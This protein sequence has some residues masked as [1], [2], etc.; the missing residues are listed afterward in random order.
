MQSRIRTALDET[1]RTHFIASPDLAGILSGRSIPTRSVVRQILERTPRIDA[2]DRVL[3]V[4][5]G[6]GYLPAVVSRL[7]REVVVVEREPSILRIARKNLER[8]GIANVVLVEGEGRAGSPGHG[9]FDLI[10]CLPLLVEIDDLLEQLAEGGS[11]LTLVGHD[12]PLMKLTRYRRAGDLMAREDLGTV[13]LARE[14]GDILIDL[15]YV[16]PELLAEARVEA[17]GRGEPV[18]SVIRRSL[19]V[20]EEAFFRALARQHN[21][22]FARADELLPALDPEIFRRFSRTFLDNHRLIPVA[23]QGGRLLL[24]TDDPD[25]D[26]VDLARMDP[27]VRLD[28]RLVTPTDFRRLWSTIDLS[29][30]GSE[31]LRWADEGSEAPELRDLLETGHEEVTQY[32]VSVYENILLDAVSARASDIHLERYD[33]RIRI[34]LRTDGDLQDLEHY[35]LTPREHAGLINVIKIRAEIDISERRLPQG[36]RSRMR[37][38]TTTYDLRVQIQ[39][40]LHGEHAVIRLLS[41]S[42]RALG[43]RELGMA[44]PLAAFYRRLLDN[45]SGLVLV[46]GPTGSGKST[47]L[48]AGLQEL[49]D[50]GHRKVITAED[51]IEY[52]IDNIQQTQIRSDIGMGF[53]DAMRAFVRQDPD[54]I[55]VG[56]IR[57]TETALEAIRA[58]QTGHIV[59]STLHSNDAVDALQRLFDLGIHANSI[60]SELL[61]VIAQRLARRICTHCRVQAQPDPGILRELFPDHVP[62]GFECFEGLGCAECGGRGTRGRIAVVETMFVNDEIRNAIS[63]QPPIAELRW[64]AL[65]NGLVTMRDSALDHV[66]EG[67][68]PLSELPRILPMERMAPEKRGGV[69]A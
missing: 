12:G 6:A 17:V 27:G 45:P 68:I 9:P 23:K 22:P 67:I 14:T 44:P 49:A 43:I 61:A 48:Y 40:S 51:P 31:H 55:L 37:V 58:S 50:Q 60:A 57:D 18:L 69:R 30:R 46:V 8:L 15:G 52:S 39:P 33:D 4:G 41:N 35:R 25:A 24:A 54:V 34:R 38:G 65:D 19:H 53:A 29:S 11:L 62:I 16:T 36:G 28:R 42:G 10:L 56:E 1:P 13:N 2:R 63:A 47:T 20:E 21:L 66:L 26:P 59:L 3:L 5:A 64:Q 32:L 7:A